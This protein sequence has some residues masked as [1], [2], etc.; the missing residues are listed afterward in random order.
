MSL[1]GD[2]FLTTQVHGGWHGSNAHKTLYYIALYNRDKGVIFTPLG[3][4]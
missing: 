2:S 4:I 3:V 1:C